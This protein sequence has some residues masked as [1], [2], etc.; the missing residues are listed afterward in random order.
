M[1]SPENNNKKISNVEAEAADK[2]G[3]ARRAGG[4]FPNRSAAASK[5][6]SLSPH[7]NFQRRKLEA[8]PF[9]LQSPAV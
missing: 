6:F 5:N 1:E 7:S 2:I 3:L 8:P 4:T 9:R